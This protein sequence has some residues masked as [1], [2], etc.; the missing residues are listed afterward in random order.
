VAGARQ[1]GTESSDYTKGVALV[2]QLSD[3]RLLNKDSALS[4]YEFA[5]DEMESLRYGMLLTANITALRSECGQTMAAV[6]GP[7]SFKLIQSKDR[8]LKYLLSRSVT[9]LPLVS[10]RFFS[11]ETICT[12]AMSGR[13][14]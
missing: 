5:P 12:P 11:V 13:V 4:S 8:N 10:C 6:N 9:R 7:L 2:G 1:H 3:C 14:M